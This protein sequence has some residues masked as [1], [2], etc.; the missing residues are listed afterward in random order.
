M[1]KRGIFTTR[2]FTA[3]NKTCTLALVWVKGGSCPHAC[4]ANRSHPVLAVYRLAR[5][6]R[7]RL[8][9]PGLRLQGRYRLA[10]AGWRLRSQGLARAS[11]RLA[12]RDAVQARERPAR[13]LRQAIRA[14]LTQGQVSAAV[15]TCP[16]LAL[17]TNAGPVPLFAQSVGLRLSRP[18]R[19]CSSGCHRD[20]HSGRS[21]RDSAESPPRC[22]PPNTSWPPP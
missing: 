7:R 21:R 20:T 13:L 6:R 17:S 4:H 15:R 2:V 12:G 10:R 5:L 8:P 14:R 18:T 16:A 19:S 22:A 1:A 9:L 11:L 3:K